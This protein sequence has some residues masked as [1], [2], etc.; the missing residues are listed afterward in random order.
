[1]TAR[2]LHLVGD[3]GDHAHYT[4]RALFLLN[5][6]SLLS[7][8]NM[9]WNKQTF[10]DPPTVSKWLATVIFIINI[11]APGEPA[12][13][14]VLESVGKSVVWIGQRNHE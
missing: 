1:M 13:P 10:I 8:D 11:I 5:L 4:F 2:L 6:S 3:G 14:N 9:A 12:G 7:G